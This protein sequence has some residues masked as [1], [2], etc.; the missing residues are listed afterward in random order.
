MAKQ[1]RLKTS[2]GGLSKAKL[3]QPLSVSNDDDNLNVE[4]IV[5]E[6]DS[7]NFVNSLLQKETQAMKEEQN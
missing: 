7:T 5:L 3:E 1:S 4:D 2:Q 6:M